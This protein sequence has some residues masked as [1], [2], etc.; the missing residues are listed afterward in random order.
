MNWKYF[1][2]YLIRSCPSRASAI[3]AKKKNAIA[4]ILKYFYVSPKNMSKGDA[5][6][7]TF[8]T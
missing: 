4:I 6:A 2:V 8:N 1:N 7:I 5:L 3:S